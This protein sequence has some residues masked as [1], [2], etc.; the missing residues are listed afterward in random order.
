VR[1]EPEPLQQVGRTWVRFRNRRLSYFS[2]CDYFRLSS[3]PRVVA[4]L[5]AGAANYGVSVAASRLTTGNHLLYRKL[6]RSLAEFFDAPEALL[7][8]SGY[9]TNLVVAQ[10]LAGEFSHALLDADC[11]SSLS[12]AARF[13]DCP[14]L[15]FKHRDSEDVARSIRRCGP[16]ARVILLTDGMFAR[17]GSVAPLADYL[18]ALPKDAWLLVDDAHGAGVVGR[19]GKG[20]LEHTGTNRRRIIQTLT[21]SKAFGAFGGAIL[22]ESELRRQILA[23]SHLFIGSTPLPL[24]LANAALE[25][26][27]ILKTDH[28]LR[29]RLAANANYARKSLRDAGMHLEE[30]PGP[31]ITLY[32]KG[33]REISRLSQQLLRSGIYPPFIRYPGGPASGYFRFVISAEHT[34]AQLDALVKALQASARPVNAR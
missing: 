16:G 13:L 29:A 30:T 34:R 8:S 6:E 9:V 5:R 18:R 19:T 2:G 27:R 7:V 21:L 24:P 17:D 12:D 31:I 15:R 22:C 14:T 20:S 32:P 26:I 33:P 4:A 11:H 1:S 23:R 3:H 10:A 25:S 28:R